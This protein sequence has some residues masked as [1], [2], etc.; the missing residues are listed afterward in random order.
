M[1]PG[2]DPAEFDALR[3]ELHADYAPASTAEGTLVDLIAEHTWRLQRARR[4]ETAAFSSLMGKND[5]DRA[6]AAALTD[7]EDRLEKI[8]RYEVTIERSYHR[9]IEQ[10]RKLQKERRAREKEARDVKNVFRAIAANPPAPRP[11][12]I[13]FVS[14]RPAAPPPTAPATG[15]VSQPAPATPTQPAAAAVSHTATGKIAA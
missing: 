7:W 12:E 11:A 1:I 10:L 5:S 13:G 3:Q 15:F 8:R 4:A 2:E 6:M 9:A 14:Q